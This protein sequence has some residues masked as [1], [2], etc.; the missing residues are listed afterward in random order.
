MKK[1]LTYF[2]ASVIFYLCC[3]YN[4]ELV[5]FMT[6]HYFTF[7]AGEFRLAFGAVVGW[8]VSSVFIRLVEDEE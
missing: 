4:N 8:M 5:E 6:P 7:Y 3:Y 2:G 1:L